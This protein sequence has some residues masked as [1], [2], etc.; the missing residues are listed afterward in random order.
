MSREIRFRAWGHTT[1]A[2]FDG[3]GLQWNGSEFISGVYDFTETEIVDEYEITV[4]Q[5]TGLKDRDGKD[6]YEG[7]IVSWNQW[8]KGSESSGKR[9]LTKSVVEWSERRG[10]WVLE[11][12]SLWNMSIYSNVEVIGN[13]YENPNLLE[14]K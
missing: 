1:G 10:A 4:M 8:A 9:K 12:D 5:F 14:E 13:V 3:R 6:I 2:M 7:D 11:K